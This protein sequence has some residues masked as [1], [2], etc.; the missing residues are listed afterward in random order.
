MNRI[1]SFGELIHRTH[2]NVND[3][4]MFLKHL[5]LSFKQIAEINNIHDERLNSI[6]TLQEFQ[7]ILE[8]KQY[9]VEQLLV[10]E[11]LVRQSQTL[12]VM[13]YESERQQE[14]HRPLSLKIQEHDVYFE[15]VRY[16]AWKILTYLCL[17]HQLNQH[18]KLLNFKLEMNLKFEKVIHSFT[19]SEQQEIHSAYRSAVQQM[20]NNLRFKQ[21]QPWTHLK[22]RQLA[23]T[24]NDAFFAALSQY[25]HQP[26]CPF[27]IE[28]TSRF[29]LTYFEPPK[30]SYLKSPSLPS[31]YEAA[32]PNIGAQ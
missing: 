25:G 5:N 7:Q 10:T 11:E 4:G 15:L 17:H 32:A 24:F 30:P 13:M 2:H 22:A 14:S 27:Q 29:Y 20:L 9:H 19:M 18:P 12:S 23:N 21:G 8:E 16:A 6:Q 3:A 28:E 26:D 31:A 1:Y